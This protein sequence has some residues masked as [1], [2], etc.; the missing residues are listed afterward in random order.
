M[1]QAPLWVYYRRMEFVHQRLLQAVDPVVGFV[2]SIVLAVAGAATGHSW[3]DGRRYL[4]RLGGGG[5][6][7]AAAPALRWEPGLLRSYWSF[8]GPLLLAGF[9][10]AAMAWS[11]ALAVKL[12]LGVAAVGVIT[13]AYNVVS[14]TDSVDQLITGALYPA[15]C[16]VRDRTEV[17]YESL[18][19]SNR[20]TLMWG[21]PFGVGVTLFGGDLVNLVTG[22]RWH[23]AILL[24]QVYGVTAALNHVGFNWTAYFRALGRTRPIAVV[25]VCATLIFL[26]VGIPLLIALGLRGIAI[27]VVAQA[28]GALVL[29]AYYLGQ[30]FPAFGF[31][32]H[33]ARS[34]R[35]TVPAAALVLLVRWLAPGGRTVPRALAE[36]AAY[37]LITIVAT[38]QQERGLLREAFGH[39]LGRPLAATSL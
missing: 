20:L 21:V 10:G 39:V 19:K 24:L 4:R 26:V 30:L 14:F 7:F 16:A 38:W 18:V 23:A 29:R 13:L 5:V 9:A 32:R 17:L 25:T 37:A 1:F 6:A 2:V 3:G 15:I 12:D 34:L 8:S 31:L 28:L 27:G 22:R 36:L 33:A 11:A 35:P